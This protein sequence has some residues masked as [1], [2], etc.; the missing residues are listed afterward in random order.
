MLSNSQVTWWAM[1]SATDR[2]SVM[3]GSDRGVSFEDQSPLSDIMSGTALSRARFPT[4]GA[5]SVNRGF[6]SDQTG[7][8]LAGSTL[9]LVGLRR[10]LA[11]GW[12][13]PARNQRGAAGRLWA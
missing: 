7:R 13:G 3:V 11:N 6:A 12:S 5:P 4:V 10:S 2:G 9:R 1:T 8:S